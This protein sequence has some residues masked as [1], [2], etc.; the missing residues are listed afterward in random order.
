LKVAD[1]RDSQVAQQAPGAP[2]V[3]KVLVLSVVYPLS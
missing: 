2:E 3:L 1:L